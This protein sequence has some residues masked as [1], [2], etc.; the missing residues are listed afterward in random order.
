MLLEPFFRCGWGEEASI[1]VEKGATALAH[2]L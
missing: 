1:L 2:S